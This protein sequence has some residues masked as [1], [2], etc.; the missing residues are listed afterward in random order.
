M[1]YRSTNKVVTKWAPNAPVKT[2]QSFKN[3]C[4]INNIVKKCIRTGSLPV[5]SGEGFYGDFSNVAD[6]QTQC[7]RVNA[8]NS[9]FASLPA[10]VRAK[11]KHDPANLLGYVQDPK[12]YEE[13]VEMGLLPKDPAIEAAKAK[14]LQDAFD[15]KKR[16]EAAAAAAAPASGGDGK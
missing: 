3:E 5:V 7:N 15:Q 13:C 14:A 4:N 12:N 9:Y 11:F 2:K 1:S 16:D 6:F 10:E 8:M